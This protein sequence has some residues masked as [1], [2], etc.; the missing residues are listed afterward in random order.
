MTSALG[1]PWL[2]RRSL[3]RAAGGATLAALGLAGC[4]A[5]AA[6]GGS[7]QSWSWTDSRGEVIARP[8]TPKRIVVTQWLLPAFWAVGIKPIGVITFMEFD[9]IA[10]YAE[11]GI[12]PTDLTVLSGYEELSLEKLATLTPDLLITEA[13]DGVETLW[14][15]AD[16]AAQQQAARI[17][18]L[19]TVKG[20]SSAEDGIRSRL[21]VAAALGADLTAAS[22]TT[23]RGAFAASV[24]AIR[25]VVGE[26]PDLTVAFVKP[27][28][29]GIWVAPEAGY[30]DL[31]H[32]ASLGLQVWD[33]P[34]AS[35]GS[36]MLSWEKAVSID[37]DVLLIDDRNTEAEASVMSPVWSRIPAV[38]A[39]QA[40]FEWRFALPYEYG[41]FARSYDRM[42]PV[43]RSARPL[44]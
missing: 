14:G 25:A 26:R 29:D 16:V 24:A 1:Q 8:A 22:L 2:P 6:P 18:P 36:T 15:F 40:A 31:S 21:D 17:A 10:G 34:T 41:A 4:G 7:D 19:L 13:Y 32:L 3:V 35:D 5:P 39:G 20:G 12:A 43:L 23:A 37:A 44:P 42:L 28:Q 33:P 9:K 38:R 27:Y 30:P 11:A